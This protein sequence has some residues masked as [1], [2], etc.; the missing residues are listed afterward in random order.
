MNTY[1]I[2]RRNGFRDVQELEQAAARS[3]QA[4]EAMAGDVRWIRSYVLAEG[5]SAVGTICIYQA[6]G[7]QAIHDHA[8]RAALPLDEIVQVNGTVVVRPDPQ[9]GS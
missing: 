8:A 1:V 4:G 7:A 5:G 6:T 2:L 9:A 3:R